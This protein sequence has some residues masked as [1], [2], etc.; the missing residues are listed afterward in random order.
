[1]RIAVDAMG[2][3]HAPDEVVRG[4]LL[5]R[6]EG[7]GAELTLVGREEVLRRA[8]GTAPREGISVADARDVVAMDEH[9]SAALRRRPD[10]SI[11]VATALVKR[12]E[13]DAVVSAG[14]TG[15]TMAAALL[16]LGRIPGIDRPALCGMLP[17][18]AKKPTCLLD[19][20]ATMDA[21][22]NNL[23]QYARMATRFM[24]GVHGVERPTVGLINVGEEPE[25]GTRL[26]LAAH[27][28]LS[29]A[30]DVTF[31]GNIEGRDVMRGITDIVLCDGFVGNVLIKGLEGT[32]DVFRDG[33]RNDIFGGILGKI[34]YVFAS[35]GVRRLRARL[36]YGPYVSA[37]LLGVNG[38]SVVTHGRADASMMRH[39]IAIAERA[40]ASGLVA[41]I[42]AQAAAPR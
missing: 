15:A 24:E 32:V 37:P 39:A 11:A 1:M 3:D 33:I 9:P 21:D 31:Y 19:A 16:V 23:L 34:A 6:S 8:L 18:T 35:V 28:L 41:K 25:K 12:G 10:T 17:T 36:D 5:Y 30:E 27:A 42:G 4:A 14:N 2:G 22:E 26:A 20:G 38:V 13:A 40:V 29:G 7:R